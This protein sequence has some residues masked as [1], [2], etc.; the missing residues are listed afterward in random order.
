[1]AALGGL[2]L[3]LKL[4]ELKING[5]RHLPCPHDPITHRE[6]AGGT[7]GREGGQGMGGLVAPCPPERVGGEG[8]GREGGGDRPRSPRYPPL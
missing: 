6:A 2:D 4:A 5:V 1:M 3:D 8:D 7:V